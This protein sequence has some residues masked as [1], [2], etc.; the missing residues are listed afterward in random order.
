MFGWWE[1][2]READWVCERERG[3]E[4]EMSFGLGLWERGGEGENNKKW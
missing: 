1:S 4:G 3:G 2:E